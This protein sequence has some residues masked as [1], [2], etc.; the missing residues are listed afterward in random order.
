MEGNPQSDANVRLYP[1]DG[2]KYVGDVLVYGLGQDDTKATAY[3]S[4]SI[5]EKLLP[6]FDENQAFG[7]MH[8]SALGFYSVNNTNA[9]LVV[10]GALSQ[11]VANSMSSTQSKAGICSTRLNNSF[12]V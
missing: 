4:P 9:K 10:F 11:Q 8:K 12:A 7:E 2:K 1:L 5:K 3:I 6:L